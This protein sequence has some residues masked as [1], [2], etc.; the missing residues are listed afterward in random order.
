[1]R[2]R[3]LP[4]RESSSSRRWVSSEEKVASRVCTAVALGRSQLTNHG[5]HC[6]ADQRITGQ[7]GLSIKVPDAQKHSYSGLARIAHDNV[8]LLAGSTLHFVAGSIVIRSCAIQAEWTTF[9]ICL[10]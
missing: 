9:D 1:M 10:A 7:A 8:S 3:Y 4:R 6:R 5:W 2:E